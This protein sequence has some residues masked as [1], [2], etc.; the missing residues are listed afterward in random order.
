MLSASSLDL[1]HLLRCKPPC[2]IRVARLHTNIPS[3]AV[4]LRQKHASPHQQK[5]DAT[6]PASTAS[7]H[8]PS[9]TTETGVSSILGRRPM[10]QPPVLSYNLPGYE[11][12]TKPPQSTF[13]EARR[14]L[15]YPQLTSAAS[16]RASSSTQPVAPP[17]SGLLTFPGQSMDPVSLDGE[18]NVEKMADELHPDPDP[19]SLRDHPQQ[20]SDPEMKSHLLDVVA[21][22]DS[23]EDAWA[24]YRM[25]TLLPPD[26]SLPTANPKIPYQHLHRLVRLFA[27]AMRT[28]TIFLRLLSVL[29]HL[30][31]SG[32][33]VKVWEWNLLIDCAG[34]GWRRTHQKDFRLALDVYADMLS[35][36]VPGA[37]FSHSSTDDGPV[38]DD[39]M[40]DR[41]PDIVTFTTLLAIAVRTREPS[42]IRHASLL[43][44]QSGI[45]ANVTSYTA[46]L[47]YYARRNELFG[48]RDTLNKMHRHD[49]PLN[50]VAF[51]AVVWAFV[52]NNRMDVAGAMYRIV[53]HSVVPEADG[54]AVK[55]AAHWLYEKETLAIP[56]ELAAN[57]I[58]YHMLIQ[59]Y[60]Y[61]GDF[62]RCLQV[63][64]DM[65]SSPV[66]HDD[67][68]EAYPPTMTAFRAIFLGFFRHGTSASQAPLTTRLS[69]LDDTPNVHAWSL[70]NLELLFEQ[71]LSLP[72]DMRP[73]PGLIYWIL[74][75]FERTSGNDTE[76]L[77]VVYQRLEDRFGGRW[78]GRVERM[79]QKIFG[80]DASVPRVYTKR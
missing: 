76:M 77:R 78:D 40:A 52:Y 51:N 66:A 1:S 65:L 71:F 55:A 44:S 53:R 18:Q 12:H 22:T 42:S 21:T 46:L 43:L 7:D 23:V 34:K 27:T 5:P 61:Y 37:S 13:A 68:V 35:G 33:R 60:A 25:L 19:T 45:P 28:R 47:G 6:A 58:T 30:R 10:D 15:Q 32:G 2:P 79:R 59:G 8:H 72:L 17:A 36:R 57:K 39:N 73:R 20:Y 14:P 48:V 38:E 54:E 41:K 64:Q 62:K 26:T 74:V 56:E 75:A 50:Q 29:S 67:N 63:F 69:L 3:F 70:A 9:G 49:I 31:Q 80:A 16:G 4:V 11:P 24:A